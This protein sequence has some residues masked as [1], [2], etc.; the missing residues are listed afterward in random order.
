MLNCIDISMLLFHHGYPGATCLD[1]MFVGLLQEGSALPENI[2]I[3]EMHQL[4]IT[5][6]LL[7]RCLDLERVICP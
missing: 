2:V 6:K 4:R 7:S 3:K 5:D 1:P